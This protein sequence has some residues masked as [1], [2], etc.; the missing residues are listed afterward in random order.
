ME[1]ILIID[2]D[3]LND[4]YNALV[5]I[6]NILQKRKEKNEENFLDSIQTEKSEIIKDSILSSDINNPNLQTSII[7]NK[8]QNNPLHFQPLTEENFYHAH[9][10]NRNIDELPSTILS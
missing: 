5:S 6:N 2:M 4:M 7:M 1:F 9:L 8:T 3:P 10:F